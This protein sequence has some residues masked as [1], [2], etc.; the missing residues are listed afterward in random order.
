[1]STNK[2]PP[3]SGGFVAQI[4]NLFTLLNLVFGCIAIVF[5]LQTGETIVVLEDTGAT[6]VQLPEK[7]WWGA[8]F[9]FAAALVDFLDGFL[10]RLLRASSE[11]GK[12]LDS[13]SDVVS[14]GVAP[15]MILYQLLR[16]GYARETG[17]LDVPLLALLPAFIF[18]GAV[19]WRLAKFNIATNQSFSFKGVPSP[20]A[21]LVVASF[22]LIILYEYF[23]LQEFFITPGLLYAVIAVLSY[24]M[25]SNHNFMAIKFTDFSVRNNRVKYILLAVALVAAATLKWLAVP[26][27]FVLYL[28]LSQFGRQPEPPA[29]NKET[30][31]RTV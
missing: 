7:I 20:A 2:Y 12:Q 24:L 22:P 19:A 17:G 23:Q 8:L 11:M 15:G 26:V 10:A 29:R 3:R 21:G 16:M 9:I 28:V 4:P 31:D 13:L 14:F 18:S 25:V 5:I 6:Q 30:V 1:M 27:V